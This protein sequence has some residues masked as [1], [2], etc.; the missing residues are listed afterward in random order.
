[1]IRKIK[2]RIRQIYKRVLTSTYLINRLKLNPQIFAT[3][4]GKDCFVLGSAPN[5]DLSLFRE[6]MVIVAVNG[7]AAN[8]KHLGLPSP[9]MTVIDFELL[10]VNKLSCSEAR[11]VSCEIL[12]DLNLGMLI[13]VQ[14]NNSQGGSP[15]ILQAKYEDFFELLKLDRKRIVQHVSGTNLLE[16]NVH[17][18]TST[19]GFAIAFSAYLGAKSITFS[20]F[21]LS[22]SKKDKE[23][24]HFY[25]SLGIATNIQQNYDI[26]EFDYDSRSHS[27]ADSALISQ[28][29]LK[30][31]PIFSTS[32]DFLPLLQNWGSNPPK[33][34]IRKI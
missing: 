28:M 16:N 30:G 26:P 3:I 13:A 2:N 19:G 1:M 20:G 7:S 21:S 24:P 31:Y 22:C 4:R 23:P 34:A 14:S 27:L 6:D 10:D 11:K 8:A 17:G 5:P 15:H 29:V 32:K 18:L 33:W 9:S 12:K 25:Q